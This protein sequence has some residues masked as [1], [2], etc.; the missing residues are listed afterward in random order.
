MEEPYTKGLANH[1]DRESCVDIRND[2]NEALT[3]ACAGWVLSLENKMRTECRRGPHT[4]KATL[5]RS[6]CKI[7]QGS[8]WSETPYM[9]RNSLRGNRE[10]LRSASL[11]RGEVR[12]GKPEGESR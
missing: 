10:S 8:A 3:A 2:G 6:I 1:G 9:H 5:G 12:I 4:R 7:S 11:N